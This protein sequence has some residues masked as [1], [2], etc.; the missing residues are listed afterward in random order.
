[1]PD[2]G[3][4]GGGDLCGG[5]NAQLDAWRPA[6]GAGGGIDRGC[7]IDEGVRHSLQEDGDG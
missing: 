3:L 4:P 2:L 1:M 5:D 7:E 6:A